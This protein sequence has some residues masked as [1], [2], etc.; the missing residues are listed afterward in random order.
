MEV[1]DTYCVSV[2]A[3]DAAGNASGGDV[4]VCSPVIE[5]LPDPDEIQLKEVSLPVW[6]SP[7]ARSAASMVAV[8]VLF[9]A[10][11]WRRRRARSMPR[12]A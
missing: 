1:G 7:R 6:A 5:L 12:W 11:R 9:A 2:A 8:L 4:E 10:W 3:L